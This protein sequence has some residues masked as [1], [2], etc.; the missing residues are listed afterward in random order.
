MNAS[1]MNGELSARGVRVTSA[2]AVTQSRRPTA[3]RPLPLALVADDDPLVCAALCA[4]LDQQFSVVA[5]AGDA[6]GAI[7]MARQHLPAVALVDVEMPGGGLKATRGVNHES[8]GTA[9]VILTADDSRSAVLQFLDAG[10]MAYLR[11]GIPAHQLTARLNEAIAAH[12]AFVKRVDQQRNAADE[13]FRAAFTQAGVGMAIVRLEG[14]DAG[15]LAEVNSAFGRMLGRQASEL[16]GA[17]LEKWTH[18]DDLPDGVRDP[19]ARLARGNVARVEF[20]QRYLHSDGHVVDALGTAASYLDEDAQ[21]VAIIQVLDISERKRFEGQLEYLADHDTLTGLFNRRRFEEELGRELTRGQRYGGHGAVLTLDLDGFKFVNDSLGHAAGDELVV[22]LAGTMRRTLRDS[23]IVARTGGDEFA[24]ILPE[25]DEP[26]ALL[27]CER[28]LSA[29]SREGIMLRGNRHAQVTT[30]I[31]LTVF[32]AGDQ[33]LADDLLVEAD[34]AM[35]D[36]KAAGKNRICVYNRDEQRRLRTTSRQGWLQRLQQAIEQDHFVLHAQPIVPVC[37][38]GVPRFEL[39][40]RMPDDRG[41]L[42]LPGTFLYYAERFDLIQPIDQWVMTQAV[43]MLHT[44]HA[45]GIDISLAI[46]VSGKT[47]NDGAIGEHLRGL[48]ENH[49]IP[50]GRLVLE[51]TETAAIANIERARELARYLRELGCQLALDDFGAGFATFYYLKYLEFDY[52]KI[53]G[54]FI[55]RLPATYADQLVVRAVVDICRG[56]GTDTIAEFVQDDD[57]L[58]L[59]KELGVGYAQG[60]HTGRPGPLEAILPQF[61]RPPAE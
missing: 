59:L 54:E 17:N 15:R 44:Y 43:K 27:A 26:A 28:L 41:D 34:I 23:D 30:S 47:L 4:Q 22:S 3:V 16:V 57:T 39:L 56:L 6:E 24:V 13:R 60:Y 58:A 48:L 11:K 53:D 38:S 40:L 33:L 50:D 20:E 14:E 25:A 12:G 36:A 5:V 7:A 2:Q 29:I 31:G 19:L 46:N 55:K 8:P 37:S 51:L 18:P 45:Q 35:Y 42:I 21:R 52:V 49:E 32:E 61:R 9:V 1:T 10:A